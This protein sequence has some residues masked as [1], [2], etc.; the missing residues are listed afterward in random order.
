M[1]KWVGLTGGIGSGKSLA[2]AEFAA[3]GVPHIDADGVSRVL[4]ADGGAALPLI[5]DAF[6]ESVFESEGRLNRAALR[7]VVFR[8]HEAKATLE[9]LMF[10]L[11]LDHFRREMQ[12]HP[13]AVYGI[14]DVPLLIEQPEFLNLTQRVLVID[15]PESEQIRRVMQRSG[16]NETEVRRIIAAQASRC[17]RLQ[18][19]DDVLH[20]TGSP[21]KLQQKIRRLHSFYQHFFNSNL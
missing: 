12:Q 21:E 14:L 7:A 2:A 11:I 5:L 1:T 9:S 8:R 18:Y 15:T 19:A 10:P 4:T 13:Q 16:L 3:L 6:G 20:N 17:K